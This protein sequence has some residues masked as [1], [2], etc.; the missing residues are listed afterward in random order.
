MWQFPMVDADNAEQELTNRLG[1]SITATGEPKYMTWLDLSNRDDYT[2]PVS[3]SK[4][5][6]FIIGET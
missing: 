6:D 3:M 5:Y 1:M 2:F 4:I